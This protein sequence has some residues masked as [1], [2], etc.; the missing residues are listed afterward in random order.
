MELEELHKVKSATL[1]RFAR[2]SKRFFITFGYIGDTHW[3]A[4]DWPQRWVD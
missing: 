3:A 1:L 2:T 4:L